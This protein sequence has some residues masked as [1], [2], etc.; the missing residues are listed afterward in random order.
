M[1][2][3]DDH[4]FT[5][6]Q[7]D[8]LD[9]LRSLPER[10][11]HCCVTSPPYWGLRD[12]GADGQIGLEQ[13]PDE[14]VAR[15]V[16]VFREVRRVLRD[17]GT[18]W[19]NLGDSYAANRSY[20]VSDGKHLSHDFGGSNASSVPD[21]LKPKDLVGIP[22]RVAFA[23][24]ADGW[25]LRS[26]VV[27]SKPNPMPE[28]VTDRPTKAHEMVFMFA[29]AKWVGPDR[30][31]YANISDEDARWLAL[32]F[33]A[34]GNVV[35]KKARN[36]ERTQYG[37][38]IA[39]ANTN[40]ALIE[41]AQAIVGE[42]S[43]H[44]REGTNAPMFYWQM[45][46]QQARDLLHRIYPFLIVKPRQAA[47]AIHM[48]DVIAEPKKRPGGYRTD[49]HTA[50]LDRCWETVKALN[51][52]E[53]P[54]ISWVPVPRYGK[55][56]AQRYFFDQ[57]AVR[58]AHQP[59]GR[60]QTLIAANGAGVTTHENYANRAQAERWPN[61]GRNIRSVWEIATQPYAQAHFATFPQALP[62]RCIKAGTS[63]QG[64][65]PACGAPW[66][67]I[68][69]KE[70]SWDARKEAGAIRGNVAFDGKV[71]AG[72]Q[73][74]VHGEGVSHNL[75]GGAVSTVGWDPTCSCGGDPVSATVLDPFMGS[76]TTALVARSLGRRAVGIELNPD[77]CQ[78]AADRLGQQTIF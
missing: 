54:D 63:K 28:S 65:C 76:G 67:R 49:E 14:Y 56:T 69:E 24:Q 41:T 5:L 17:D 30:G 46:G 43:I 55:W 1:I 40:R 36:G 42:G 15:M 13:T 25:V 53:H 7:G 29:K 70:S 6:H 33:D 59:D 2:F 9:V 12:Y 23:L 32:L 58:E 75:G 10:S 4:N 77:Y 62:E 39:F 52:F 21:G 50:F 37:A 72:T 34:E 11:I 68:V 31:R 38:Q 66:R 18:L 27:W 51:S 45:T 35:V 74:G 26:D 22:W 71:G 48:Q 20:Q 16:D 3:V 78:L 8:C 60:K 73:R 57:E 19:L 47:V 64:V 61:S 44:E